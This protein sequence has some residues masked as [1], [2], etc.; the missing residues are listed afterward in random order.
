MGD[1]FAYEFVALA[2]LGLDC[3]GWSLASHLPFALLAFP[4]F[5]K[6]EA[7]A[8]V[9]DVAAPVFWSE[10][11]RQTPLDS[12]IFLMIRTRLMWAMER[13]LVSIFGES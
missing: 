10:M 1:E 11:N 12:R 4:P 3:L 8:F 9:P 13:C 6:V 7:G 5:E 2:A